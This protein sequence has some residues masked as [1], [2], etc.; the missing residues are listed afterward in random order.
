MPAGAATINVF[1]PYYGSQ[2]PIG[3]GTY[4]PEITTALHN[5]TYFGGVDATGAALAATDA[6]GEASDV[7]PGGR[8]DLAP[9]SASPSVPVLDTWFVNSPAWA[10][11]RRELAA[12]AWAEQAAGVLRVRI[13]DATR[14]GQPEGPFADQTIDVPL[15][16]NAPP[17]PVA[18]RFTPDGQ[19]LLVAA[20]VVQVS[21]AVTSR[22]WTVARI[23]LGTFHPATPGQAM[24]DS[25]YGGGDGIVGGPFTSG[26]GALRAMELRGASG[27]VLTGTGD[28][29]GAD[30]VPARLHVLVLSD[31]GVPH[32]SFG[33][34]GLATVDAVGDPDGPMFGLPPA[35][36]TGTDV[37]V[38]ATGDITIAGGQSA[39]GPAFLVRLSPAGT[40]RQSFGTGGH[41][42]VDAPDFDEVELYPDGSA[43]ALA[44]GV[45]VSLLEHFDPTGEL[46]YESVFNGSSECA[47]NLEA[48]SLLSQTGGDAIILAG[49][50]PGLGLNAFR[51]TDE[52]P[53]RRVLAQAVPSRINVGGRSVALDEAAR[54]DPDSDA[55][56][57]VG[58]TI[59]ATPL[60]NSPLRNSPLRN[61]PL[62]NSPLRNS[63]LRNSPLTELPLRNSG[64]W[65]AVLQSTPLRN[66][67]LQ[68]ITL[69]DVLD[70]DPIPDVTLGDL[71]PTRGVL[72]RVSVASLL[73]LGRPLDALPPPSA[74]VSWCQ[75]L[76]GLG[77][78]P[79]CGAGGVDPAVTHT[80]DL[81]L[82]GANLRGYWHGV[83]VALTDEVMG[84][85]DLRAPLGEITLNTIELAATPLGKLR[86]QDVNDAIGCTAN[87]A[88][89]LAAKQAA[90]P[91]AFSDVTLGD[92]LAS[93]RAP[94][95]PAQ[96]YTLQELLPGIAP[97]SE[98]S[99][100][101][102]SALDA[103]VQRST[104][105]DN[106]LAL[107]TSFVVV[108]GEV[109]PPAGGGEGL[110]IAIK[111]PKLGYVPG[112]GKFLIHS[113]QYDLDD[114]VV[115][116]DT[117]T[118]TRMHDG[119]DPKA[120]SDGCD[121]V[122]PGAPTFASVSFDAEPPTGLGTGTI[123]P[124]ITTG[125]GLV[126]TGRSAS[127][128]IF[129]GSDPP[130][131][132]STTRVLA[133][134][135]LYTGYIPSAGDVDA[136]RIHAPAAGSVVT[137]S[138]SN[139][140][141]DNDL[142][143][144]G[145]KAGIPVPPSR[146]RAQTEAVLADPPLPDQSVDLNGDDDTPSP[147]A[148]TGMPMGAASLA[149]LPLRGISNRSGTTNESVSF[150][151][152]SGDAGSDFLATVASAGGAVS[153]EAYGLRITV[154]P[155][156]TEPQCIPARTGLG[157]GTLGT[158]PSS[159]PTTTQ[160]LILW[161][162]QRTE[163]AYPGSGATL[164]G[165][166][167]TLA[168]APGVGGAVIPVEADPTHGAAVRAALA[169]WDAEP[170]SPG[171]ANDV[172]SAIGMVVDRL[173]PQLA[174]LRHIVLVGGDDLLPQGR[175]PDLVGIANER[176]QA[177]AMTAGGADTPISRSLRRGLVLSDDPYGD[178]DPQAWLTGTLAL[179]DVGLGRLVEKPAD[180]AAQI[181]QYVAAGGVLPVASA[182]V[183]GY[184]FISDGAAAIRD[185]VQTIVGA[186]NVSARIDETWTA[187]DALAYINRA[188]GGISSINGHYDHY[189]GLPAAA[190]GPLLQ[191]ADAS[192]AP[193][194]LLF[195]IGCHA[196]LSSIDAYG[197][198]GDPGLGDWA[199]QLTKA[200]SAFVGNTG[201]GYGDT[202][203]VAYSERL[204]AGFASQL[205]TRDSTAGQ[206]LMYAKQQYFATLGAPGV[207]DGKALQELTFYGLPMYRVGST[208]GLGAPALPPP[209]PS[210]SAGVAKTG[211]DVQPQFSQVTT[212]RG[213]Y[214][215]ADGRDPIATHLR[216]LQ[217][218]TDLDVTPT[219][220]AVVHGAL[221]TALASSDV[222]NV[223]PVFSRP[224]VDL[225]AHEP[226]IG[227]DDVAF[228]ATLQRVQDHAAADGRHVRLNLA[229]GQFI[230][231]PSDPAGLGTQRLFSRIAGDVLRSR[232]TDF[233]PPRIENIVTAKANGKVTFDVTTPDTDVTGGVALYEDAAGVW[234]S[235]TLT[236]SGGHARGTGPLP[237]DAQAAG[238]AFV[239]LVDAAG[240]VGLATDKGRGIG[241][242][243]ASA[244][245]A[246]APPLVADPPPGTGGTSQPPVTVR[247]SGEARSTA[248]IS[249]DGSAYAPYDGPIVLETDG[250]HVITARAPDGSTSRLTVIVASD[251]VT[252][253]L[254]AL[255]RTSTTWL[256]RETLTAGGPD[257]TF[258]YGSKPLSPIM[259]DWDGDG[260]QT[261]G[262]FEGGV[263]K[264]RNTN[265]TG[266]AADIT[267]TFG[268]PRGFPVA[269]D[270]NGD[271]T[272]DVAVFR[273]GTWQ[274]RLSTG[275]VLPSFTF[276]A[277]TWPATVPVAG[278]WDG[279][280]TDG[281]GTYT[282]NSAT[283]NLRHTPS[284]GSPD[285]GPVAFGT[286]SSSYPVTGD[287]DA[288][289]DDTVGVKTGATWSLR[290]AN[291]P[292]AA[293]T[294]FAYGLANDLPLSWR[295]P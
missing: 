59:A 36:Q 69:G 184:D 279:D 283:W 282:Y 149:A 251:T 265:T 213:R 206:A 281:V 131:D 16:G 75:Y 196:G 280:G 247:I 236:M 72:R 218:R 67:P 150:L 107:G 118:F 163:A 22:A 294:S 202:G 30:S 64:G 266:T 254:P 92:L 28:F 141:A 257:A 133:P 274:V 5:I 53:L 98:L 15:G 195:T 146:R 167:A 227:P 82:L 89:T 142:F 217:P 272:D 103:L 269:G 106:R 199:A 130:G 57:E 203:S 47:R 128:D 234:R 3:A 63:P 230:S 165:K 259:G 71:D 68:T 245:G 105:N 115:D 270:F 154:T 224:T 215:T 219:D 250:V 127:Y 48:M 95:G 139:L 6:A 189:R 194:S 164:A 161:D 20:Q 190:D 62:R 177:D 200:G 52:S 27:V 120:L 83:P 222:A 60:R 18:V 78:A 220:G 85:G 129:D 19:H 228:P 169:A 166:L 25:A 2:V 49:D 253:S 170:C 289:G 102:A 183:T 109:A 264:L 207:Y 43:Y 157:S 153:N 147:D 100:E 175:V 152:Q 1:D 84:S 211:F 76:V 239:Q 45:P 33:T 256:L 124:T 252:P 138:L 23:R 112:S 155:P 117:W 241:L 179:P 144:Q 271:G 58:G 86:Q 4:S 135:R 96:L 275:T 13:V 17:V 87:C 114:P 235:L 132:S 88:T 240:N 125:S 32:P 21:G 12:A 290:N 192:P 156:G 278:D 77:P 101:E 8:L 287:W 113:Q 243:A 267:F 110:T 39:A 181:D 97:T 204:L 10:S 145:P 172:V 242:S 137:V 268:D 158:F 201:F 180:I 286:A 191:A 70:L 29:T 197:L 249:V 134:D 162:R 198:A 73:L 104:T 188:G 260:L 229:A 66:S 90:D 214:W 140:P 174:Q 176:E 293:D 11:G 276:G 248:T 26:G 258:T 31:F 41:V 65:T 14:P 212:D 35:P 42:L 54:P 99:P 231:D 74:G 143:V 291:G 238:V 233:D 288:D 151:V 108:C 50:C 273:N 160:T 34:A 185:N 79:R 173:R 126:A 46:V 277:G 7:F 208:G 55:Q 237:G 93:A 223:D 255:V 285:I 292:G 91:G 221:I 24:L 122:S 226:E 186:A 40:P 61:S 193:G 209:D 94:A 148:V 119:P 111:A 178:F 81:E 80:F 225:A 262:T 284:T 9:A 216:P 244:P 295:K 159:V 232:S 205:A 168:G 210:G 37:A 263:F 171:A 121:G 187:A 182:R 123:T 136:Y 261:A 38:G 51:L 246:N 44:G 56:S 116:G